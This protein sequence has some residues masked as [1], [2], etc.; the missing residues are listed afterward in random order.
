MGKPA[1]RRRTDWC[2]CPSPSLDVVAGNDHEPFPL[3]TGRLGIA[4][5][6]EPRRGLGLRLQ[7]RR[8]HG[9]RRKASH[10]PPE[11]ARVLSDRAKIVKFAWEF[12]AVNN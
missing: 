12:H 3:L 11:M 2:P 4:K 10:E 7:F 6:F 9:I 8:L 1:L 5:Q